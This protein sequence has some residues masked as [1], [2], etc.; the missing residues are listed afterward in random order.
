VTLSQ[1]SVKSDVIGDKLCRDFD[2][3]FVDDDIEDDGTSD[4]VFFTASTLAVPSSVTP[5]SMSNRSRHSLDVRRSVSPGRRTPNGNISRTASVRGCRTPSPRHSTTRHE[6]EI[7]AYPR[8][9]DAQSQ[10]KLLQQSLFPNTPP[11]IYFGAENETSKF[12]AFV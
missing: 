4:D 11:T 9:H 3:Q 10:P 5:D 2:Y 7:F 8:S 6:S 1:H 12:F